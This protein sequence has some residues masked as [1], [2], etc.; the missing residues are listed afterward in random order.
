MNAIDWRSRASRCVVNASRTRTLQNM[1]AYQLAFIHSLGE[2]ETDRVLLYCER[3]LCKSQAA[4]VS[5]QHQ[6][7]RGVDLIFGFNLLS[8]L[9]STSV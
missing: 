8:S 4:L 5:I 1:H 2:L 3:D 7:G 6:H 9:P